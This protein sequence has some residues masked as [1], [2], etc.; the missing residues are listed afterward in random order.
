MARHFACLLL[1]LCFSASLWSKPSLCDATPEVRE[2]LRKA[3]AVPITEPFAAF[4]N[5]VPFKALRD[6]Y[7]DDL[8]VHEA[9][10]DAMQAHG[11]EGHLRYL[12]R[13]YDDLKEAHAG[14]PMYAYLAWRTLVGRTTPAAI[15]GLN[16]LLGAHPEFAPAHRTLAGIYGTERYGDPERQS[17]ERAK[18]F[19]LCPSGAIDWRLPPI[20]EPTTRIDEAERLLRQ[21]DDPHQV[22]KVAMQG[23]SE[24][25]WR[26]QRIR[27]FDW[28]TEDYKKQDAR[29]L[30]AKNWQAWTVRV[31]CHWK[32][33][34]PR[35][36][37]MLLA[38]MTRT[39]PVLRAESETAYWDGLEG[40]VQLYAEGGQMAAAHALLAN[41]RQ[42][43]DQNP[44]R[45]RS[46]RIEALGRMTHTESP[47][48]GVVR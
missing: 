48:A 41:M 30:R 12:T 24:S 27:A 46:A 15:D 35:E 33:G 21:G 4:R 29:D 5:T 18:Y 26:S 34:E 8:F 40:L 36:A 42:I 22:A 11:I 31:R 7:P 43:A 16:Q 3:A 19:G 17:V 10:Q 6:R 45:Q 2:V 20:P 37:G 14:N 39:L 1:I 44:S 13:E 28:Y 25:E 9:Y 47:E 32:S 23:Q 38:Q